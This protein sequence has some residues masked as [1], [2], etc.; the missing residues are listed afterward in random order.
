MPSADISIPALVHAGLNEGLKAAVIKLYSVL[1]S[2][3][4]SDDTAA[5]ERFKKGL[6]NAVKTYEEAMRIARGEV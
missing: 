6:Q 1:L 2:G 3:Q 4:G 5:L